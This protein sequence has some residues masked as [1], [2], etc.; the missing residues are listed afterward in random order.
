[1]CFDTIAVGEIEKVCLCHAH[2]HT[3]FIVAAVG[4]LQ[5]G[6]K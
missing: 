4:F 6:N 3:W 2:W 5:N 1:M